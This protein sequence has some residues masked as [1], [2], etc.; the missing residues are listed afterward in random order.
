MH[1]TAYCKSWFSRP[2]F[3]NPQLVLKMK[4]LTFLFFAGC[5]QL[6]ANG[7]TQ[8]ITICGKNLPLQKVFR[9]L[10][11]QSGYQFFYNEKLIRQAERVSLDMKGAALESVLEECFKNQP[12]SYAIVEKTIVLKRKPV[13]PES[14]NSEAKKI[15]V[16]DVKGRVIKQNGES[17]EMVTV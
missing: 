11:K 13:L 15:L 7:F 5:L 1:L 6:S 3:S 8:S 16:L 12:F 4:L 14:E 10:E 9:E 17:V 2:G